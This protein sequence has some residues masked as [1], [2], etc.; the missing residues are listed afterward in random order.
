MWP[1]QSHLSFVF[2]L[3][4]KLKA[5]GDIFREALELSPLWEKSSADLATV[6]TRYAQVNADRKSVLTEV[7]LVVNGTHIEV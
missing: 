2:C 1:P 5:R 7:F 3:L 6:N 4:I